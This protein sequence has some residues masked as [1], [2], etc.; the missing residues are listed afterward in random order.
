L[1]S[2][3]SVY[4]EPKTYPLLPFLGILYPLL[5]IA[6]V[7]F[8]LLWLLK[9]YKYSFIS[10]IAILIGVNHI[11]ENFQ[12]SK[13]Q[14]I[15]SKKGLIKL[16]S[17]NVKN[18]DMYNYK[19]HWQYNFENRNKI[20]E[21]IRKEAPDIICFQEFVNDRLGQFKTLDTLVKFQKAVNVH[22][23]YTFLSRGIVEFGSATFSKYPIVN[24]GR[25]DFPNSKN[26]LCIYTDILIDNQIVR[27]YN[28]HFESVHFSADDYR[29]AENI[30]NIKDLDKNKNKYLRIF[31]IMKRAYINRADQVDLVADHIK[32]CKYP[33]ILC[34]DLNDTPVS[35]AYHNISSGLKDA[36]VN[37]GNGYGRTLVSLFTLFRIDYIFFS[38]HFTSYSF[39]TGNVKYSDHFPIYCYLEKKK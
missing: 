30:D 37:S 29:T 22:A 13:S 35:Y 4:I 26:N 8:V 25:I 32:K 14:D 38:K 15:K 18:F 11:M 34:T 36:F 9:R 33:I 17:Y 10:L 20:Y 27:V 7:F 28:A 5:L 31:R 21:N 6:N 12:Y 23:E 24:K 39:T 2:Y 16:M 19:P 1:L 3:L